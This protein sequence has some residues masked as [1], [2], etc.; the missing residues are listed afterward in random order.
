MRADRDQLAVLERDVEAAKQAYETAERRFTQTSLESQATQ[1]NVFLIRPAIEPL[2]PSFPKVKLY[3]LAAILFGALL[4]IGTAHMLETL[5]RRVRCV[6]DVAGLVRMRVLSVIEREAAAGTLAL[7]AA[8]RA[9]RASPAGRSAGR[10]RAHYPAAGARRVRRRR[11]HAS[12]RSWSA[13]ARSRSQDVERILEQQRE[14]GGRF[15]DAGRALGL[16]EQRDIDFA[17]SRQFDYPYLRRGESRVSEAVVAAYEP[18]SPQVEALRALRSELMLH[19]FSDDAAHKSLA[20]VSEARGDGRS[21]IAANLAVVLSQLGG[22]TLLIDADLRNPS[23]HALFGLENR[24][25]LSAVLAG[26]AGAEAVQRV[27]EL[28]SLSVLPAGVAPPN[29]QELLARADVRR[30]ARAARR[31]RRLHPDRHAGRG[32]KRGR[33][34][35]RRARRRGAVRGAQEPLAPLAR[36][37]D[38]RERRAHAQPRCSAQ[39]SMTSSRD[40]RTPA[41]AAGDPAARRRGVRGRAAARL[42]RGDGGR[43]LRAPAQPLV[44]PHAGRLPRPQ[45][46]DLHRLRG[47]AARAVALAGR[48][49]KLAL[50]FFVLLAVPAIDAE[51]PGFGLVEHFFAIDYLRLLALA[52]LLPA[53]L[54]LRIRP[55]AEPFGRS[56]A[57]KLLLAYLV[58]Q[59]VLQLPHATLTET[60]RKG[61]FYAFID[62][63]LPYYVASRAARDLAALREAL[64]AF[65]ARRP[66]G[67]RDRGV[68]VRPALAALYAARGGARRG[69]GPAEL[70]GARRRPAAR[71][72]EH[73][74]AD[75]PRLRPRA[76]ARLLRSICADPFRSTRWR[77]AG[78]RA[79]RGRAGRRDVARAVD[80]RRGHAARLR[81][82]RAA[83]AAAPGEARRGRRSAPCRSS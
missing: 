13:P 30:A 27:A 78:A 19:W 32:R 1:S 79:A 49:N 73:R 77:D 58:L 80:R 66:G 15:G 56:R 52:V 4:G 65:V 2:D 55:D 33:A 64:M 69:L 10:E 11:A 41:R 8:Q 81:R 9:A 54:A 31:A 43:G 25:G 26:R 48:A 36:A 68:R 39:C 74:A 23:Q 53:W 14:K 35:R 16:L 38:R 57:D 45:L 40:A 71:A 82:H 70:P 28:G 12:A 6:E 18:A 17:L 42:R 67:G 51:I 61:A 83:G 76:R 46:L 75:R 22:R 60:L 7:A 34:D 29:P 37:G 47:R 44:R 3:I 72:G 59:F 62:V 50:Y 5:D 21:Y 20:V 24:I 63:F